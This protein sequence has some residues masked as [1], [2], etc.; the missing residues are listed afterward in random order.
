M[1]EISNFS[2][3]QTKSYVKLKSEN[4]MKFSKFFPILKNH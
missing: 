4:V 2:N 3:N 1:V